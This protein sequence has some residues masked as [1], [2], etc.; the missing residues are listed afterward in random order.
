MLVLS[1][2][3]DESVMINGDIEVVVLGIEGDTVKLGVK[4][5]K[6]VDIYRKELYLTIQA[7]N[8]EALQTPAAM[9][10]LKQLL[11]QKKPNSK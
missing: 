9:D 3:R 1:R 11:S 8:Q 5:P 6:E 10:Q 7:A 2:K 4:A